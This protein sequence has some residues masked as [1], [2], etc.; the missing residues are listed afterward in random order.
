MAPLALRLLLLAALPATGWLKT[1]TFESPPPPRA[2]KVGQGGRC[3]AAPPCGPSGRPGPWDRGVCITVFHLRPAG[4]GPGS[5]SPKEEWGKALKEMGAAWEGVARER[6]R[7]SLMWLNLVPRNLRDSYRSL[8]CC[9]PHGV[10]PVANTQ[11][12]VISAFAMAPPSGRA[13]R[14]AKQCLCACAMW[15]LL[16]ERKREIVSRPLLAPTGGGK[17]CLP[18]NAG[19]RGAC[20]ADGAAEGE[21][22]TQHLA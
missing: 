13:G 8:H 4:P 7:G 19:L 5:G 10:L 12:Q 3:S 11:F 22:K 17:D 9:H 15:K 21:R 14:W 2:P 20:W 6:E 18:Q 16:I 1:G